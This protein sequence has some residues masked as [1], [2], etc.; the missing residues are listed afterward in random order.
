MPFNPSNDTTVKAFLPTFTFTY[1][2]SGA[3]LYKGISDSIKW[4]TNCTSSK[5]NIAL[6]LMSTKVY[7]IATDILNSGKF[8]FTPPVL[9]IDTNKYKIVINNIENSVSV[10]SA[11][12]YIE[13]PHLLTI[14]YPNSGRYCIQKS[15]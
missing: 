10:T 13:T 3:I 4:N 15:K 7:Q 8:A 11:Y 12:F 6:Y 9:L 1:P 2:T 5:V 14:T